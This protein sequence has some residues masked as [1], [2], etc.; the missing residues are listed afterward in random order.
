M[1]A[2]CTPHDV[3]GFNTLVSWLRDTDPRSVYVDWGHGTCPEPKAPE[4]TSN[5]KLCKW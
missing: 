3:A 4:A 2:E 1:G 5:E